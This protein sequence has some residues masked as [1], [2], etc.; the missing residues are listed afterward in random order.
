MKS[1]FKKS[2]SST[3]WTLIRFLSE[4]VCLKGQIVFQVMQFV[5][6]STESLYGLYVTLH[7]PLN[8]VWS[9]VWIHSHSLVLLSFRK[10]V[11]VMFSRVPYEFLQWA[12]AN[13]SIFPSS[14][15][16]TLSC[17]NEWVSWHCTDAYIITIATDADVPDIDHT[18]WTN[19][20]DCIIYR[21]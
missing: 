5:W 21:T 10:L 6:L 15:A 13:I 3:V 20:S 17:H 1:D 18:F 11:S 2:Q 12:E 16:S 8:I 4:Y 7:K 19:R 9:S 14:L